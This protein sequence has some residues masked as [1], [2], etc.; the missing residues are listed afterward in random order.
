MLPTNGTWANL[1]HNPEEY[2]QKIFWWHAGYV[3][4][5]EPQ[6]ELKVTGERPD[7]KVPPLIVSNATNAFAD[8]IG[9]AMLIGVDFPTLGCRQI[10]GKYEDTELSFVLWVAQ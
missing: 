5:G 1:P 2:T 6:S 4:N 10:T 9:S 8:D 7:T 3:W